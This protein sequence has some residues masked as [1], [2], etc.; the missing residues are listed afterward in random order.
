MDTRS[1][2]LDLATNY[3]QVCLSTHVNNTS[4]INFVVSYLYVGAADAADL[5]FAVNQ[6]AEMALLGAGHT[7]QMFPETMDEFYENAMMGDE[8]QSRIIM[9]S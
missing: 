5:Q 7:D 2:K 6:I 9:Q 8:V 4:G 3:S 1:L